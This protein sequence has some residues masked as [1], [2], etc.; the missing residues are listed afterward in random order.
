MKKILIILGL[1]LTS[2]SV[3]A[4]DMRI[5]QIDNFLYSPENQEIADKTI[6]NINKLKKVDFVVFSGNNISKPSK[7][8]LEKFLKTAKKLNSPY[9]V[10]LGNKDVNKQKHLSKSEY[11]QVLQKKN[12][13]YKKITSPNY[14]FEKNGIIFIVVDGSKEVI[15][16]SMGYYKANVMT[17]LE[18]QLDLYKDKKVIIFQH[19]PVVA[20]AKKESYYT[21]K[22]DEYLKL[23]D[24]YSNIKALVA[25]HF[26]VNNEQKVNGILHISTSNA[27]NFRVIDIIDYDTDN[28]T[29]W[30]TVKD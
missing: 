11:M 12:K 25:G 7:D 9:Y 17:W 29:F 16:S 2:L 15:P 19:F 27:P 8:Y 26:N 4:K 21:Y 6:A 28:M 14:V 5:V 23:L 3:Q 20:P 22:A 18:E 24:N 13:F 1:F 10:V 30:A